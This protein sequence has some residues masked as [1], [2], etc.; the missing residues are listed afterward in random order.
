MNFTRTRGA[1]ALAVV[2]TTGAATGTAYAQAP[3]LSG[4]PESSN[5]KPASPPKAEQQ[6]P[7]QKPAKKRRAKK[8]SSTTRV[9]SARH[10]VTLGGRM[11]VKGTVSPKGT[12]RRVRLQVRTRKGW[13]SVAKD[14]SGKGGSFRLSYT[15]KSPGSLKTRVV[16]LG[17]SKHRSSRR[18]VGRVDVFRKAYASWY[19]P[20]LYGNKLGC[21]GRLSTGTIGVAHKSLP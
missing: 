1:I 20:G 9:R 3:G 7:A 14:V 18:T 19:G 13:Q 5:F 10:N 4:T 6:K 15:P 8:T 2:L 11:L 17:D 16:F 12:G 21:G